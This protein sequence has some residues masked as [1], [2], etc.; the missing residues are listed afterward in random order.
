LEAQGVAIKVV[1]PQPEKDTRELAKR[2]KVPMQFYI[3][4][5][6][7]AAQLLGIVHRDGVPAG[8]PGYGTDTVF[9]TVLMCDDRGDIIFSDQTNNYRDRP[10]PELYLNVLKASAGA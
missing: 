3:D 6:N 8:M 4:S 1:T 5:D 7:G 2:F 10:S 9:P